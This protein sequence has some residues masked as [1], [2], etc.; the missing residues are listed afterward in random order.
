MPEGERE[1]VC[2]I[3][4]ETKT[5]VYSDAIRLEMIQYHRGIHD[6]DSKIVVM[7]FI[8]SAIISFFYV[9]GNLF[10]ILN[11]VQIVIMLTSAAVTALTGFLLALCAWSEGKEMLR[12]M[13]L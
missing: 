7:M 1:I 12:W 2:P 6:S 4:T 3:P 9:I 10:W 5:V 11:T 8:N 13:T